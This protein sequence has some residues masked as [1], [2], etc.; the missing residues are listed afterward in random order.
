MSVL[1]FSKGSTL[2]DLF[3]DTAHQLQALII[4]PVEVSEAIREKIVL[5]APDLPT[6]LKEWI[7]TL[8]QL[9]RQIIF[10]RVHVLEFKEMPGACQLKAEATGEFFDPLRHVFR[11]SPA[12]LRLSEVAFSV[13]GSSQTAQLTFSP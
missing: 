10:S 9:Q 7:Q 13:Q 11:R 2:P 5:E 3:Q 12:S 6:L 4:D 8:I 1:L